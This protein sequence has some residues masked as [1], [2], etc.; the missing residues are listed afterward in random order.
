MKAHCFHDSLH[1][2]HL[3]PTRILLFLH[4]ESLTLIHVQLVM[5]DSSAPSQRLFSKLKSYRMGFGK[6][7]DC[8]FGSST[9]IKGFLDCYGM[10]TLWFY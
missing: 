7:N 8:C 2:A 5:Y 3:T 1:Y 9:S 10:Y 6:W 4:Y